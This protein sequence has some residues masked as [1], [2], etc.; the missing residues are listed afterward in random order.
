MGV[1]CAASPAALAPLLAPQ[2]EPISYAVPT[3]DG[4][5]YVL[6]EAK[7]GATDKQLK[8]RWDGEASKACLGEF[9]VLSE[10]QSQRNRGG[11]TLLK[12]Y[13]GFVR[14][15]NPEAVQALDV[16]ERA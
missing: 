11:K 15:V 8:R 7:K 9:V 16:P 4:G 2:P 13:E 6:V 10:N 3:E 12:I 1:G 14:C 5:M